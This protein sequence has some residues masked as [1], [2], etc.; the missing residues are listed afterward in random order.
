VGDPL[1]TL[2]ALAGRGLNGRLYVS[3]DNLFL[4]TDY[5]GYDPE[6]FMGGNTGL[7]ARGMDYLSY[8]RPRTF[9]AGVRAAF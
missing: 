4:I 5:S 3:G 8:P 9:T 7:A 1:K 2:V 6:V